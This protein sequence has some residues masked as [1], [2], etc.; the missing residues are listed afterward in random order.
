MRLTTR[1]VSTATKTKSFTN[2]K[3]KTGFP[4]YYKLYL[5]KFPYFEHGYVS[6]VIHKVIDGMTKEEANDKTTEAY[7]NGLSLLRVCP[8]EIAEDYCEK[9]R[10]KQ[11][12]STI[13][14]VSYTEK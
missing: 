7:L 1:P 6:T 5:H 13:E 2:P 4:P 8:Q 11:I 14:P 10:S 3:I 12:I 9:I